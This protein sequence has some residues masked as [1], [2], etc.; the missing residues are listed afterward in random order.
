MAVVTV[1]TTEPSAT[2]KEFTT[3]LFNTWKI[4]KIPE[5][6]PSSQQLFY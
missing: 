3:Q 5:I 1:P 2:P 4:G 6:K